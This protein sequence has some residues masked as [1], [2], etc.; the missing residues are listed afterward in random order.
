MAGR[1]ATA[2]FDLA[3]ESA[4]IDKIAAELN[5]FD[6]LLRDS[7]DLKRFIRSPV[8][9]AEE[10]VR[11]LKA[12]LAKA[13]IGGLTANFLG[14]IAK[15]RRLFAVGDMIKAF[16]GLV[17]RHKGEVEADVV[18]AAALSDTQLTALKAAL[19]ASLGK[20]VQMNTKVDPAILGGLIVK[21]GS[22]MIDSSLRTKLS[23]LKMRMKEVQ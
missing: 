13:G 10:Q 16:Q 11:A 3:K 4:Q 14:L 2:L 22:R 18:S 6:G 19:K 17:A 7:G 23:S 12:L 9:S 21:V 8:F 20:D 1:Y 5:G 15:N